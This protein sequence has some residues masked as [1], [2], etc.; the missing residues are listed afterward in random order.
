MSDDLWW[1]ADGTVDWGINPSGQLVELLHDGAR[2]RLHCW[3]PL[4]SPHPIGFVVDCGHRAATMFVDW[5]ELTSPEADRILRQYR[6]DRARRDHPS[7][8]GDG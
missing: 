1:H 2:W 4:A 8:G 6:V 3:T 5:A 7:G